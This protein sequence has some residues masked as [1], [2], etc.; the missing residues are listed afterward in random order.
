MYKYILISLF[1]F[2]VL[3]FTALAQAIGELGV[4]EA[5]NWL[6]LAAALIVP[7]CGLIAAALPDGHWA[8]KIVNMVALNFGKAKNDSRAQ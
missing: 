7:I 6:A 4:E 1:G 8:M 3:P 5:P 2:A